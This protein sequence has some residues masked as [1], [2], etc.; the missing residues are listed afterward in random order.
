[1]NFDGIYSS[2]LAVS[3]KSCHIAL[4]LPK[5]KI[6]KTRKKLR[7]INFGYDEGKHFKS[8]SKLE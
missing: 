1:M 6:I 3:Y 8:L 2:D 7:E 5:T 4:G